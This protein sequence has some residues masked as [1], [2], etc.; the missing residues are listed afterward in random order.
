MSANAWLNA[1]SHEQ[2]GCEIHEVRD[3]A[4]NLIAAYGRCHPPL[5]ADLD[6]TLFQVDAIASGDAEGRVTREWRR[7]GY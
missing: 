3:L 2:F 5:S 7:E 4:N 6:W 1:E